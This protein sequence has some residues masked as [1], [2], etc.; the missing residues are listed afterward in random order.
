[1]NHR[2]P[3]INQKEFILVSIR[4]RHMPPIPNMEKQYE[5]HRLGVVPAL[6]PTSRCVAVGKSCPSLAGTDQPVRK[7]GCDSNV[8]ERPLLLSES[9]LRQGQKRALATSSQVILTPQSDQI[10]CWGLRAPGLMISEVPALCC[11]PFVHT[12]S[13]RGVGTYHPSPLCTPLSEPHSQ[14]GLALP[15][16]AWD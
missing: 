15:C 13:R 2:K 1:M 6:S 11:L 9:F 5:E 4:F 8:W 10:C 14:P 3:Y 16:A 7:S 12:C